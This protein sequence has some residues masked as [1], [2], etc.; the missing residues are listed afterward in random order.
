ML[1]TVCC[2][3]VPV[4]QE[5]R[6]AGFVCMG[7]RTGARHSALSRPALG[8]T[9]SFWQK[10]GGANRKSEELSS[11]RAGSAD[12]GLDICGL[13]RPVG[14]VLLLFLEDSATAVRPS[15]PSG[16]LA[17]C[18]LPAAAVLRE[19]Q[20][21]KGGE[22]ARPTHIFALSRRAAGTAGT[23][24]LVDGARKTGQSSCTE[25]RTVIL[26][27]LPWLASPPSR[28]GHRHLDL[29]ASRQTSSD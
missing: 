20:G 17:S 10:G 23:N 28:P 15:P 18:D 21:R 3:T 4:R 16:Q 13:V 5:T 22:R 26:L 1:E 14:Q 29:A 7:G 6:R 19:Q 25:H 24:G 11:L 9:T 12:A 27:P 2:Q 8:K